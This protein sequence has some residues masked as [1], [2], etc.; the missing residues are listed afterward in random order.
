MPTRNVA[1]APK[2]PSQKIY[3]AYRNA[4][5]KPRRPV[6]EI[7]SVEFGELTRQAPSADGSARP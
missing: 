4:K 2:A 5:G 6:A 3:D 7:G 1:A